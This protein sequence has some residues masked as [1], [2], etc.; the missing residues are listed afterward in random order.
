MTL[1]TRLF[2]AAEL[3]G[4]DARIA[5]YL[6][7][8]F[9]DG[10]PALIASAIGDVARARNIAAISRETGLTRETLYRAFSPDGNP[11]LATLS[12]VVKAL[13]FQLSIQPL[14]S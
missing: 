5:A 8:A 4:D 14:A 10:D 9:A 7:E 13:G 11:T 3:L 2:D 1:E 6:E 12:A